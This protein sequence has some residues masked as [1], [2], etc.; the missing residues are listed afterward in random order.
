MNV[1][2]DNS[3]SFATLTQ[4]VTTEVLRPPSAAAGVVAEAIRQ[5]LGSGVVAI[6][7]YG[8]CL[9]TGEVENG[10]LDFYALVDSYRA[11]FSSRVLAGLNALLPPNVF[12][13]EVPYD[14]K[15]IRAKY[16][17]ISTRQFAYSVSLRSVHAGIWAR[18]CQPVRLAYTHD[19][20][21]RTAVAHALREAI[22]T[23]VLR[24]V[25]LLP[26]EAAKEP[27]CPQ[28]LWHCG[29][30]ATYR[31]EVRPENPTTLAGLYQA[32]PERYQQVAHAA[33]RELA[34]NGLLE[35]HD[36]EGGVRVIMPA[37]RRKTLRRDWYVRRRLAKGL[38]ALR[39]LKSAFTFGD[40][41][42]YS[43]WKLER[44][45]GVRIGLTERQRRA[46]LIW[47]WPVILKLLW[48]RVLR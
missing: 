10:V 31:A 7:F 37:S 35:L 9:R 38:Y 44:H 42:P 3:T 19:E 27:F 36:A 29:F 20:S 25:A 28:A 5:Q 24:A 6:L 39:L 22:L 23:M 14:G 16:A 8:S 21:T 45:T 40:W 41:L 26:V 17:V 4:L 48:Q 18:F 34:Q 15:I 12:Y 13:I 2:R 43:L 47:G 11:V 46:P 30:Q 33:L 32:A 1:E